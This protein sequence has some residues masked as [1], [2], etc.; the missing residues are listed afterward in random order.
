MYY[1]NR[2]QVTQY[3]KPQLEREMLFQEIAIGLDFYWKRNSLISRDFLE[4]EKLIMNDEISFQCLLGLDRKCGDL[5]GTFYP[6]I[7]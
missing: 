2:F 3:I 4:L 1:F 7:F 6:T 5:K